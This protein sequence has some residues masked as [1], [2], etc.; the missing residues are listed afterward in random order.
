MHSLSNPLCTLTEILLCHKLAEYVWAVDWKWRFTTTMSPEP[1][2]KPRPKPAPYVRTKVKAGTSKDAPATSVKSVVTKKY[3][4][5][6]LHDWLMVFSYIDAHPDMPQ[7]DIVEHFKTQ[8]DGAL[9]FTQS[10]LS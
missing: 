9:V 6:T 1:R 5:L 10:T 2:R 7:S 8:R 4:T 3:E